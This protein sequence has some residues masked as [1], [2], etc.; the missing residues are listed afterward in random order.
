MGE[1]T[2][3]WCRERLGVR[4]NEFYGQTEANLLIGNCAAWPERPGWMG[5]AYPG[6]E[7][8]LVDG[9]IAVRVEG[10]PVVF[11]GYWRDEQA[12]AAKV[13]DGWLHTGDLAE[14]DDE[15][16]FRS[17]GRVDDLISSGGHRIG[18]GEIEECLIRHPAVS[19]AA[20]IGT[21]DEV[22]GEVVKAFVVTVPGTAGSPELATELRELV[23]T[24][25]AP[26][27]VPR[28]IEFVAE[29]PLT[30]TGKIRRGELRRIDAERRSGG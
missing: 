28:E 14:V 1:E 23:R 3:A 29:V 13:R 17:V 5:R 26:F 19:I 6:H 27:E 22:R 11:L 21:P 4:L 16:T 15:G 25:L 7:L 8:R 24:R 30:V 18:P 2:A 12:T 10:D 9:E 20:A